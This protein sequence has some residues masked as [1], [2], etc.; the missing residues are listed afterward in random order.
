MPT[1]ESAP[2]SPP[3]GPARSAWVDL[4]SGLTDTPE[5]PGLDADTARDRTLVLDARGIPNRTVRRGSG[6]SV[7]VPAEHLRAAMDEVAAYE[8]ENPPEPEPEPLPPPG[9]EGRDAALVMA[10]ALIQYMVVSGP[11][12]SLRMY[13]EDWL[14]AGTAD[15]TRILAGQWW[16]SVTA[17]TLHADPAHFLAN[18]VLGGVLVACLAR[19]AGSG[20][21]WLAFVLSGALGNLAN[22]W[23]RGP[24]HLCIGAST[25]VFGVLGVLGAVTVVRDGRGG[26]RRAAAP[27]AAGLALLGMLGTE[28]DNTDLGAHLFGFLAGLPL[29]LA[30][31]APVGRFGPPGRAPSTGLGLA[32]L[33]LVV[34]AWWLALAA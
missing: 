6:W 12:P 29:G 10:L 19:A 2:Q 26:L 3:H 22:A 27:L 15:S 16:R 32:A 18:A 25:A 24:G 11:L 33:A 13:P 34:A 9:P 8:R 4:E 17:L 23:A 28:G 14:A 7:L 30:L 1:D 20:A 5:A 21:A 31:G